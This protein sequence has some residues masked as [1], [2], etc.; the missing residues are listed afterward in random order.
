MVYG[1]IDIFDSKENNSVEISSQYDDASFII[2][3]DFNARSTKLSDIVD[4]DPYVVENNG[5]KEVFDKLSISNLVD[6]EIPL[7]CF[8]ED[9]G[10]VN[11]YGYRLIEMCKTVGLCIA[12]G[13][14]FEDLYIGRNTCHGKSLID[15]VLV[16]PENFTN[17]TG[18][19]VNEFDPIFSDIHSVIDICLYAKNSV[20]SVVPNVVTH[21][22]EN[23]KHVLK[24]N[25]LG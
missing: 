23:M 7:H 20:T 17:M 25:D 21:H 6:L 8:S 9:I 3:G 11:N 4:F 2:F 19:Q 12:N 10:N 22:V 18:F 1:S 15:Y 13:R 24:K 14:C 5:G 16:S